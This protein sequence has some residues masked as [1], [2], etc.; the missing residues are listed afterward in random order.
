MYHKKVLQLSALYLKSKYFLCR[1]YFQQVV[2]G[3]YLWLEILGYIL[4]VFN[5]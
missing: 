4:L 3:Y 5:I 1:K 2:N